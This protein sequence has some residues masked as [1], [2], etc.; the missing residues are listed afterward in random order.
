MVRLSTLIRRLSDMGKV[1]FIVTHDYEFVCRS[2]TR[3]LHFA[4]GGIRD[5]FPVTEE[6]LPTMKKFFGVRWGI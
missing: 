4:G 3:V 5:D 6:L 2:C 1:I